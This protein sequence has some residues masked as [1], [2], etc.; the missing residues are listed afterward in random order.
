M[1][2]ST[3]SHWRQATENN[4]TP[5]QTGIVFPDEAHAQELL[6]HCLAQLEDNNKR[7]E[8]LET[9]LKEYGYKAVFVPSPRAN[10][11]AVQVHTPLCPEGKPQLAK[12]LCCM[13]RCGLQAA[14]GNGSPSPAPLHTYLWEE[15]T[16]RRS[17]SSPGQSSK[18]GPLKGSSF[19]QP[20]CSPH[21]PCIDRPLGRYST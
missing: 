13:I 20:A 16:R 11:P 10:D 14:E 17:Y 2:P 15:P 18:I 7:V 5:A 19:S 1:S 21:A 3:Q 9:H 8:S 6:G 4:R 12:A